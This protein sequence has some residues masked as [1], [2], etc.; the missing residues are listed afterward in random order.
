MRSMLYLLII[1]I[2]AESSSGSVPFSELTL[3]STPSVGAGLTTQLVADAFT[4]L[5]VDGNDELSVDEMAP[6]IL[7]LMKV[8]AGLFVDDSGEYVLQKNFVNHLYVPDFTAIS[9]A[10]DDSTCAA[11]SMLVNLDSS[12]L[13][14]EVFGED[15]IVDIDTFAQ[16]VYSIIA[17][18]RAFSLL[19]LEA[20]MLAD[21]P[22]NMPSATLLDEYTVGN[23]NCANSDDGRRNLFYASVVNRMNTC[24]GRVAR[25]GMLTGVIGAS[26]HLIEN[27]LCPDCTS[28]G[29]SIS[30]ALGVGFGLATLAEGIPWFMRRYSIFPYWECPVFNVPIE[31]DAIVPPHNP[32][33]L[34]PR[35]IVEPVTIGVPRNPSVDPN[36]GI[37]PADF[38]VPAEFAEVGEIGAL[39][40]AGVATAGAEAAGA[41]ALFGE[42]IGS[43]GVFGRR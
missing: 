26:G 41:G 5:D 12:T 22:T 16:T 24:W 33:V 32:I 9:E 25:F 29:V 19:D 39:G 34:T 3:A 43:V 30:R 21:L 17:E 8:F 38:E 28:T 36:F 37:D 18:D 42:L 7:P 15:A 4:Q 13:W 11:D 31:P 14:T 6:V 2:V 35:N 40:E 27:A 20:L 10:V 1:V 23:E